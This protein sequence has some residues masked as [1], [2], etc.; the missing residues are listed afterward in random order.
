MSLTLPELANQYIR[1]R[2]EEAANYHLLNALPTTKPRVPQVF[3]VLRRKSS[4][5][6]PA[7]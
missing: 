7:R 3:N 4:R 6:K 2:H 1:E 5:A